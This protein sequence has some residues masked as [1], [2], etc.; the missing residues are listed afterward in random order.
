MHARPTGS[1]LM[2]EVTGEEDE[3]DLGIPSYL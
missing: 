3:V 1:V 2:E